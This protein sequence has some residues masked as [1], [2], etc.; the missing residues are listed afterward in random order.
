M[1]VYMKVFWRKKY[2]VY[3]VLLN[4]FVNGNYLVFV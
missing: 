3:D 1:F 4:D 2:I